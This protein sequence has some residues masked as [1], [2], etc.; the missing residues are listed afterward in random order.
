[1]TTTHQAA[2]GTGTTAPA[3]VAS[4]RPALRLLAG[5]ALMAGPVLFALGMATTPQAAGDSDP[6]YIASLA[7][8]A[9]MTQVSAL[10][11]H[12]ANLLLALGILAAPALVRGRR[13]HW[14]TLVGSVLA[15][16]AFGNLSG[17]LLSDWWNLSAGTH[18]PAEQAVVVFQGFKQASLLGWWTGTTPLNLVGPLLVL[19]GLVLAGVVRWW[20]VPLLI[21]G[22]AG[23]VAIPADLPL[24]TAGAVLVGFSPLAL[25]GLRLVARWR[26]G[27]V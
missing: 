2:P 8:D 15:A 11:L 1:M 9:T 18:L 3:G 20:T 21:A 7:H 5:G 23:L 14:P 12:Y 6:A 17:S 24:V 26:A 27:T 10:F 16:V 25:I 4:R 19:V 13:G 22:V